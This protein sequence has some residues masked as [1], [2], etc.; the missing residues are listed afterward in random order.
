MC[1]Q[2]DSPVSPVAPVKPVDP[3]R[4]AKQRDGQLR[5]DSNLHTH[6]ASQKQARVATRVEGWRVVCTQTACACKRIHLSVR[7]LQ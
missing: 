2:E 4:P 3:V 7:W 5:F 6:K 1:M